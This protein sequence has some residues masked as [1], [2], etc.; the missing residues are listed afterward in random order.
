MILIT[1]KEY[2]RNNLRFQPEDNKGTNPV[3]SEG[4]AQSQSSSFNNTFS[5]FKKR[6]ALRQRCSQFVFSLNWQ[7]QQL[8]TV[9]S[10][11]SSEHPSLQIR[12][13]GGLIIIGK[14]GYCIVKST[15]GFQS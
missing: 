1:P 10:L 9:R 13:N 5:T 2:P 4:V 7:I 14:F 11:I 6:L 8:L 15:A 12:A 3:N